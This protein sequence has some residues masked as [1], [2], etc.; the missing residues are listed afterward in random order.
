MHI[1]YFHQLPFFYIIIIKK[2]DLNVWWSFHV[3][4]Y[5][6]GKQNFGAIEIDWD[7]LPVNLK[8]QVR[9]MNGLPVTGVDNSLSEL[10]ESS[11]KTKAGQDR[12]HCTLEK[13]L[14]WIV[15]YRL[16]IL[17]YSILTCKQFLMFI[18][19]SLNLSSLLFF[20]YFSR[21]KKINHTQNW[22]GGN[23]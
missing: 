21:I 8:L 7:T 9:D 3:F 17:V 22:L 19:S 4:M 13:M 23:V 16:A 18:F 15:R 10:R 1:W 11:S 5:S 12:K 6:L 2:I 20:V 14:P